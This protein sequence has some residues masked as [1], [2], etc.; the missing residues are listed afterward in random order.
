MAS[1]PD[2]SLKRNIAVA[3]RLA[4]IL[5]SLSFALLAILV[6]NFGVSI[7][8]PVIAGIGLF[9]LLIIVIN[10]YGH[11][12]LGRMLLSNVP[13][14]ITMYAALISKIEEPNHT[15]ILYY[16]S[17]FILILLSIVP[18]LIFNLKEY[19]FLYGSLIVILLSLI[20]FD[21][22]HEFFSVGYYQRGF[23]SSSYFYI[24]YVSL[25]S[26]AGLTGGALTLKFFMERYEATS[27][28]FKRDVMKKNA[29]LSEALK[30]IETQNEEIVSQSE[31]LLASQE[32]L[33]E[34]NK[35]IARQNEELEAK[36]RQTNADL[37]QTNEELIRRNNELSQFSYTISHNLRGPVARLLGLSQV[38]SFNKR[39]LDDHDA[40]TII[41][42]IQTSANDLDNVFKDLIK[43]VDTRNAI[44][45]SSQLCYY[46][47]EWTYVKNF[48]NISD[49]FESRH[50]HLDFAIPSIQSVRPLLNS[51]IFNLVS[52]AIKYRSYERDLL[53]SIRTFETD[54]FHVL[55]VKDNGVGIDLALFEKD[56]F[57]MYK[58]FH[59]TQE[60]RGVGLYLLKLQVELLNGYVKVESTL[61]VGST[62]TVYFRKGT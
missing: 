3:N 50:I 43:I 31:E 11:S 4:V 46:N 35:T 1:L 47:E 39:I 29:D 26:F 18:C 21:P 40:L 49:D 45:Q 24:N 55:Q 54:T 16:D 7:T 60:G 9:F 10:N 23:M 48:L 15:D 36:V 59:K 33:V 13:V 56:L 25:I 17:R 34:A 28:L 42:H 62:F 37:Y 12:N 19:F 14:V 57:K 32:Q 2:D 61:D 51:I 41:S 30:N 27:E 5:S 58:R 52:N 44:D 22:I 6:I 53:V 8:T 20:L 38:A